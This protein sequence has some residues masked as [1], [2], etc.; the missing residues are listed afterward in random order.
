MVLSMLVFFLAIV[1]SRSMVAPNVQTALLAT[2]LG[3]SNAA[4]ALL[5]RWKQQ[6]ACAVIW[7]A[8]A[9]VCC[10]GTSTLTMIG[11]MTATFLCWIVFGIYV[12]IR[13]SQMPQQNRMKNV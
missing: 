4:C 8:A 5:L 1:Y 2:M 12:T 6:F 3:T 11:F 9:V 10:F 13:Q 7:W